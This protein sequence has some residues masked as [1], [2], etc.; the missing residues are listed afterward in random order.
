MCERGLAAMQMNLISAIKPVSLDVIQTVRM[1]ILQ[2]NV[3]TSS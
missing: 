1:K 3:K 2:I